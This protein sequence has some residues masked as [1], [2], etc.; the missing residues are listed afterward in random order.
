[1]RMT[2]IVPNGKAKP[3]H[4]TVQGN[5]F[6]SLMALAVVYFSLGFITC[7]NDT[8]VPFFKQ[9]FTLNYAESSLVQFYF[10]LTYAMMS[11]PAG[12]LIERLGYQRG[13]VAGFVV[14]GLGALL[15]L[16]ASWLHE[17]ALFLCALF[18][19][20]IG[21]VLLQVAANPY[22][23][24]L[25]RPETAASR[26]ALIQ[27]VGSVGTTL[28]PLFGARFIL[29]KVTDPGSSSEAVSIPYLGI[30]AVLFLLA[31]TVYF[32]SLPAIASQKPD[33]AS[34]IGGH[35]SLFAFRNLNLGMIG[36]FAYVG[37]E[38]SIG[39][40]LTNYI[41]DTTG[42]EEHQANNYVAFYW[43]G[44][45]AGRWIG[46]AL[47]NVIRPSVMLAVLAVM[48]TL[49]ILMSIASSGTGA[50]WSMVAVGLCN[51][52]MF[53]VV[54]A[55]AIKGLDGYTTRASGLLSTAIVGGAVVPYFQGVCID[56]F[57][58]TIA[59]LLPAACYLYLLFFAIHGHRS[60]LT[61][62]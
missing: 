2:V 39:T 10:F 19:L 60:K 22:I 20:A 35:H 49:L 28:A 12:K 56:R 33:D 58:W 53:A 40:F 4:L 45:L 44:M 32:L 3:D 8:L 7:L 9:G 23:T 16:P 30:A 54:F 47:L 36:I 17:Y 43:G 34:E 21:I 46:S 41:A 51:S 52:V 42:I 15:F 37:A 57:G 18:I 59:F 55:M 38:V 1:M 11:I 6:L 5:H 48:A 27:G 31:A 14:A 61:T 50:I 13:M 29:A 25:G 26:L 24:L 62:S